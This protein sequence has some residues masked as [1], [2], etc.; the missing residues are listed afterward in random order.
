MNATTKLVLATLIGGV[1][2]A[3]LASLLLPREEAPRASANADPEPLYWVAPMDPD[4]RRDGPGKSPMGMDLVPVYAEERSADAPGTV[5]ISPQVVSNLGVRTGEVRR[6]RLSG[7]LDTVGY[8]QYDEDRLVHVHPRV[9]GWIEKLYVK[10][11]GDP[12]REGEPLYTLYSPTLVNAQEELLLSLKRDNPLLIDAAAE[13]LASLQVPESAIAQLRES[14]RV[15]RTITLYAPQD[16][17]VDNLQ[18]REGMYVEPGMKVMSIGTLT[19]VWV[20][21]EV[22]ERQAAL[23]QTGDAVQM[24][25]DYLP[26]RLWQGRV[27]YIYP[28]LNPKTRTV[29]VRIRF[30]NPDAFL[31]PGMFAQ[32]EIAT[33]AGEERLLVPREALI[34]TGS[35]SRVVLALGEGRF[36]SVA[37][38]VGR[39][40]GEQAE[41]L[42]GV[43]AGDR[44]VTSAQFLID[45]ESSRSSDF[46]RMDIPKGEM[47]HSAHVEMD[48]SGHADMDHAGPVQ[49]ERES[50]QA[51][52][53]AAHEAA[54]GNEHGEH[55]Q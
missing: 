22:F 47:D 36:R 16:G 27:D 37:V 25:L 50:G 38:E 20:I 17:V 44:I 32:M 28:T 39:I 13:R 34:R 41:I 48:H 51:M 45:S 55:G 43:E 9:A 14:G 5:S 26:G 6:G 24:R 31:R 29:Q 35:Q 40:A 21:A 53:H 8:V 12:V 18:A 15:S 2:G 23:V 30:E 4:Y 33:A 42:S 11:S 10:A 19:H 7:G 1:A 54:N 46:T 49:T 52:D 3:V